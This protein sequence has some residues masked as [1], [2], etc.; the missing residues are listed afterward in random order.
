MVTLVMHGKVQ[1]SG[2]RPLNGGRDLGQ[3][4]DLI[5]EA[6]S[7]ELDTSG[8]AMLREM[9]QLGRL[10][11]L[12]WWFDQPSADMGQMFAGF[13]WVEDGRIVGN[14]TVT[15]T[16]SLGR[17]WV[18]SNV[19]VATA[20]RG[21]GI[22]RRLMEAAV[23]YIREHR[24]QVVTLQVRNNNEPA[25]HIYRTMGFEDVFSTAYMRLDP[26]P[27][28]PA[29]DVPGGT[30]RARRYDGGEAYKAYRLARAA[31]PEYVQVEHPI[32]LAP[33]RL[34]L[35]TQLSDWIRQ[36]FAAGP[37]L[38]L[39]WEKNEL[40]Q[41]LITVQLDNARPEGRIQLLVHPLFQ[42]VVEDALISQALSHLNHWHRHSAVVQQPTYHKAAILAFTKAGFA[43]E[44]TL[45]WMKR[46]LP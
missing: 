15:P 18:I 36:V 33:Y 5:Q 22:A 27:E 6:F 16:S 44:R 37:P 32:V 13:V 42:G 30:L 3:V 43:T 12:F 39:V 20:Y 46:Q 11:S 41:A 1:Q 38:R 10:G 19:A 35:Q 7:S 45:V 4:A 28:V 34:G 21:R 17:R 8:K 40:F 9:R 31:I 26:V 2:L 25:L 29:V 23:A 14:I 24:G